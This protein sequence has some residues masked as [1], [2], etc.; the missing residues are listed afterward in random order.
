MALNA[1]FPPPSF[2]LKERV[3]YLEL[4]KEIDVAVAKNVHR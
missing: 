2:F 4:E 1:L 3:L